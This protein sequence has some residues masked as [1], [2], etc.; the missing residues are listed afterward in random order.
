MLIIWWSLIATSS[1]NLLFLQADGK[2]YSGPYARYLVTEHL[3]GAQELD[4]D[5]WEAFVFC[6]FKS[7][8]LLTE[9]T[10]VLCQVTKEVYSM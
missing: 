7:D 4:E 6:K 1:H 5:M 10:R 2:F 3:N 8:L 9:N